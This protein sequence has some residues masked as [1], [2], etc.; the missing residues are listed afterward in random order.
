MTIR[1]EPLDEA[2]TF[3]TMMEALD[4]Y[5]HVVT[6]PNHDRD[7]RHAALRDAHQAFL[8]FTGDDMVGGGNA[9]TSLSIH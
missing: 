5:F 3:D 9:P 2:D 4:W 1:E 6:C 8:A 7:E